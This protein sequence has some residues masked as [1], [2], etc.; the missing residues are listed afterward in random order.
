MALNPTMVEV[1]DYRVIEYARVFLNS[2]ISWED[3]GDF[4]TV[5]SSIFDLFSKD[6]WIIRMSYYPRRPQFEP[7][8]QHPF[9]Y[10]VL[11]TG[12]FRRLHFI[13]TIFDNKDALIEDLLSDYPDER[14]LC[15]LL[16]EMQL[17]PKEALLEHLS[18][19]KR[20][21]KDLLFANSCIG[22]G[23]Q[24]GPN[25]DMIQLAGNDRVLHKLLSLLSSGGERKNSVRAPFHLRH[26]RRFCP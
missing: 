15:L 23:I 25:R 7:S 19:G 6:Y 26:R 9:R 13:A 17:S 21:L 3:R 5:V 20:E 10:K 22:G 2:P 11:R 4:D 18:L 14:S 12:L 24:I 1:S 8:D 16:A